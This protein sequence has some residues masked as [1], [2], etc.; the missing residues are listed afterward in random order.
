[1]TEKAIE[2]IEQ[3]TV[4]FYDDEITAVRLSD[5]SV[6]IPIRPLCEI[7][8]VAWNGQ[9]ERIQRDPVLSS[10]LMSVRVTRTDIEPSSRRPLQSDVSCL[11]LEYLNGWMFGINANRVKAELRD[12]I[13]RYQREC[14]KVL[15]EAFQDRRLATDQSFDDLLKTDSP[16]AQAYRMA[17]AMM[18][19]ARQQLLLESRMDDHE[20]RLER[21]ETQINGTEQTISEAQASQ[22]SQAVKAV[23]LE[24]SKRNGRNEYGGVYGEM[25][26]R[27][28]I[29]SYK[30]LPIHRF[31]EAMDWLSEWYQSLTNETQF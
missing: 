31:R 1:M 21:L 3:K 8:G 28:E 10:V 30:L 4:L 15:H 27:Y 7:L 25:Y 13:I 29:T 6:Y 23:A 2:P 16:A 24:L 5:G 26:R 12:R 22:I 20:N 14:Y 19:L 11:P 18:H 17:Q 9:Y